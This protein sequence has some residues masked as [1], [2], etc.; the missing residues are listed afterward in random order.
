[1]EL[2]DWKV[3]TFVILF[4]V[5]KLS[6]PES[7][8]ISTPISNGKDPTS[9]ALINKTSCTT[10][11]SCWSDHQ[12]P[13]S[14]CSL[15]GIYLL[16]GAGHIFICFRKMWILYSG[17]WLFISL[18]ISPLVCWTLSFWFIAALYISEIAGLSLWYEM[19]I[20]FFPSLSFIFW[21]GLLL[22]WSVFVSLP[23]RIF[24]FW[25]WIYLIFLW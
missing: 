12:K 1:M 17:K 13:L 8:P 6:S 14:H 19:Q 16:S 11:W 18:P 21:L 25:S 24:F 4:D 20:F 5:A 22:F 15:I 10:F 9:H 7:V 23:C 3:C 2:L